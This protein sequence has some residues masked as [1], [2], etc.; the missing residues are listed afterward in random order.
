MPRRQKRES[1]DKEVYPEIW[2]IYERIWNQYEAYVHVGWTT[3]GS[4]SRIIS[5][6]E[7]DLIEEVMEAL[8]NK[9]P[10]A[11]V[12]EGQPAKVTMADVIAYHHK[13]DKR[14]GLQLGASRAAPHCP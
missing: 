3:P 14:F 5:D 12:Q 11:Y 6:T 7:M 4:M 13:L 8:S 9:P 1:F 2:A 10:E